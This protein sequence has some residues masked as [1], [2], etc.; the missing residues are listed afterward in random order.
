MLADDHVYR[1]KAAAVHPH[2]GVIERLSE[3]Y[4]I[5]FLLDC[6]PYLVA[7]RLSSQHSAL[8]FDLVLNVDKYA[9]H[10]LFRLAFWPYHFDPSG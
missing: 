1:V 5:I 7:R 10:D 9:D 2:S 3:C 6:N 8:D 4:E